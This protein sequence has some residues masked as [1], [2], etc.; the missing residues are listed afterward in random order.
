LSKIL[1]SLKD[2]RDNSKSA[3]TNFSDVMQ[4]LLKSIHECQILVLNI[5]ECPSNSKLLEILEQSLGHLY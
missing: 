4:N 2:I 5:F 1:L 3:I